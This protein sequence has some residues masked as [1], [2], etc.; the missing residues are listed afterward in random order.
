ML[1]Q[2]YELALEPGEP[3]PVAQFNVTLRPTASIRLRLHRRGH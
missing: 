3:K 2:R 1:L